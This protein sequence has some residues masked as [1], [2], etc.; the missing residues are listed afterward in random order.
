MTC[1]HLGDLVTENGDR[2]IFHGDRQ[3]LN[4]CNDKKEFKIKSMLNM[5]LAV[6]IPAVS[7]DCPTP[8]A[9]N[10]Q[11]ITLVPCVLCY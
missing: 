10:T 4:F 1:D 9:L 11:H 2:E 6:L 8:W 5:L 3:L 7:H